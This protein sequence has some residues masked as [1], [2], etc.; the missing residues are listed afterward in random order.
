MDNRMLPKIHARPMADAL[1]AAC[2][3]V[4]IEGGVRLPGN[5]GWLDLA[6]AHLLALEAE[7]NSVEIRFLTTVRPLVPAKVFAGWLV[8]S[9]GAPNARTEGSPADDAL[10]RLK[11]VGSGRHP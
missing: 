1:R 10:A 6:R 5:R 9:P 7:R 4:I 11:V 2:I 3:H 8:L